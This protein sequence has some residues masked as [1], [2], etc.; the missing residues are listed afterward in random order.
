MLKL[1]G[2]SAIFIHVAPM[3]SFYQLGG[4]VLTRFCVAI[5]VIIYNIIRFST[6]YFKAFHIL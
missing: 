4:E 1:K 6:T 2:V 3:K 5:F